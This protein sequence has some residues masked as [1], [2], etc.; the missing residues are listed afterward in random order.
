MCPDRRMR[1]HVLSPGNNE[2]LSG[3]RSMSL[4]FSGPGSVLPTLVGDTLLYGFHRNVFKLGKTHGID[5]ECGIRGR[6][7]VPCCC[8][9]LLTH[10]RAPLSHPRSPRPLAVTTLAISSVPSNLCP[11]S[12]IC[13]FPWHLDPHKLGEETCEALTQTRR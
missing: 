11:L 3:L 2:A 12:P 5:W 6:W 9:S 1:G 4:R 7:S 13:L 8:P 10:I